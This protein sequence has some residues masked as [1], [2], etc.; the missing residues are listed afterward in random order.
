MTMSAKTKK[1]CIVSNNFNTGEENQLNNFL[2]ELIFFLA[3]RTKKVDHHCLSVSL[4]NRFQGSKYIWMLG[5]FF[6]FWYRK[7]F[8]FL[9]F[10]K[11][12]NCILWECYLSIF[13]FSF[14]SKFFLFIDN[15]INIYSIE[16]YFSPCLYI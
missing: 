11:C 2:R 8:Y 14:I 1:C 4:I 15:L 10:C 12:L 9:F 7:Y 3:L 5:F 6:F 13:Q 16:T